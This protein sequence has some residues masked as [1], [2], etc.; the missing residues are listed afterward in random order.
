MSK[1]SVLIAAYNTESYLHQ[2]LGS[3][4]R[5]TLGDF[6]AICVDDASTDGTPQLLDEYALSDSRFHVIHLDENGG[7]AKARNI[8]LSLASGDYVCMLDSDDWM[9][10]D[11]LELAA[12]MLDR[13]PDMDCVLFQVEEVYADHRRRY[14][15]PS[16]ERMSGQQAFEASLTWDIHGL[17]MLRNALHQQYPYDDSSRAYSDDNTTRIHYLRS[18]SVGQCGGIYY[19]RQH[20][21]SVTHCVSVRHFDYLRANESMK[22]Q[23]LSEKVEE[24]LLDVYERERWLNLID[25]YL[26]YTLHRREL[27]SADRRYALSEM[28]RVWGGIEVCR[29]PLGLRCKP[30]Y[31]PLRPCWLL[32]RLQEEIYFALRKI[33]R[34][35]MRI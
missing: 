6:E 18:R 9:S 3:L 7:Q 1:V 34:R 17:Y 19:Y 10:D 13:H 14:P 23:M 11:A 33:F 26:Y 12:G 31:I 21:G 29:L 15:M 27:S 4:L 8:A 16:F 25:C 20:E 30:G 22:R 2:C 24:R 35:N 32:F 28:R 5:Q